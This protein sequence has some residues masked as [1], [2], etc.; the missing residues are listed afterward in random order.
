M[1]NFAPLQFVPVFGTDFK[2]DRFKGS[3]LIMPTLSAGMSGSIGAD[4]YILNEGM[5]KIGYLHSEYISPVIFN[6]AHNSS[7]TGQLTMPCE[8]YITADSSQ[9]IINMRS[10]VVQG[11]MFPFGEALSSFVSTNGFSNVVVLSSTLSPVKRERESN[12]EF[13]EIFAYVNNFL[14]KKCN[15][16]GKSYYEKHGIRQFGYWLGADKKK[17]HQELEEMTGGG[18]AQ[19]LIKSFNK[20]DIPT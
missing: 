15:A 13:P 18:S 10:G 3:Q 19:K 14:H 12:R 17:A 4:M 8:V 11:K 20:T 7:N 16:E 9:T 6:D 5:T 2:Q 1:S